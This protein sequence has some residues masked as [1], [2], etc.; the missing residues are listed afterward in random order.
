MLLFTEILNVFTYLIPY[1]WLSV[2]THNTIFASLIG[3]IVQITSRQKK[4]SNGT[5]EACE[6]DLR[7]S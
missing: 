7:Y 2:V 5:W 6:Q 1:L 4:L 3:P